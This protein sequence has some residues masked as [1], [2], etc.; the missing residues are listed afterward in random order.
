MFYASLTFT[1]IKKHFKNRERNRE[2]KTVG[3]RSSG[4]SGRS[5]E[6]PVGPGRNL[7]LNLGFH[8]LTTERWKLTAPQI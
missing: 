1:T 2:I 5:P 7:G 3:I 4:Y 6:Y 8:T